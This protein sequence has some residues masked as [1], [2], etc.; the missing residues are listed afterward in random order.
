MTTKAYGDTN[1][2]RSD[3]FISI[4]V[5][6][7]IAILRISP[8]QCTTDDTVSTLGTCLPSSDCS[9]NGVA[10]GSCAKGFGTCCIVQKS[11][12]TSTTYDNT[13]FV[14]PGFPSADTG[15]GRCT[16]T[17]NRASSNICQVRLDFID[18]ELSQ[19]DVNGECLTDFLTVT[20]GTSTVPMICGSNA[21]QHSK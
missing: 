2:N 18:F 3:R 16:L 17:V 13:Y 8:D 9:T 21:G 11:C 19:P 15:T 6:P 12:G 5:T 20:G 10:S 14:N 4:N 7:V 1:S